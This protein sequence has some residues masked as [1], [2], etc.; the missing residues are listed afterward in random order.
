MEQKIIDLEMRYMEQERIIQELSEIIYRQEQQI[1]QMQNH[2][3]Q[4]TKQLNILMPSIAE[5]SDEEVPPHY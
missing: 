5:I 4:I 1:S 3:K 2:L